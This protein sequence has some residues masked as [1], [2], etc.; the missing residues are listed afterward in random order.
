MD[1]AEFDSPFANVSR[2]AQKKFYKI[3]RGVK[4]C[5]SKILVDEHEGRKTK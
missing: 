1:K 2:K 3:S 4:K 5:R